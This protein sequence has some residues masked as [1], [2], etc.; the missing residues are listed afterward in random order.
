MRPFGS[1]PFSGSLA[2]QYRSS[3][4][5]GRQRG[6][7]GGLPRA[8]GEPCRRPTLSQTV[9][10][11]RRRSV[12]LRS[13]ARFF[14]GLPTSGFSD[15]RG[16]A[17]RRPGATM[18]GKLPDRKDL[19]TCSPSDA[20]GLARTRRTCDIAHEPF[21]PALLYATMCFVCPSCGREF[22]AY[23]NAGRKYCCHPCY[24][25]ARFKGGECRE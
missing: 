10:P 8:S 5:G 20:T 22:T 21:G 14:N 12:G 13:A 16:A 15:A 18:A 1:L 24:I 17:R 3:G 2:F 4:G 19:A 9:R 6:V 7:F 11:L 25:A 23:G